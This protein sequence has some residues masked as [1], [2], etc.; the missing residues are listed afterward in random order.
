MAVQPPVPA[1]PQ[2]A[3]PAPPKKSGCA[4]CSVGCLGCLGVFVIVTLLLAT[5]G[6]FFFVASANA[7]VA[8]PAALLVATT[9]VEVGHNDSGYAPA[10]SGQSLDAG[11]S[12]RTGSTG[13]ATIQFPDGS[14]TR[15]APDTTVT[16]TSAQLNSAGTLKSATLSEKIGRTLSVVQKLT[17]G[18]SFSVGG[19]TVTAAVRGTQFEVVVNKDFSNLFKVFDGVVQVS[20]Q[21]TVTLT[22]GQQVSADSNG[23]VGRPGPIQADLHDPY[24]LETQCARA[25]AQGTAAG[26]TQTTTGQISNGETVEVDYT[27]SGASTTA[28]L[29]Y[30]GSFI[31]LSVVDPAGVTHASRSGQP[32]VVMTIGRGPGVY[33]ALVHAI[34]VTPGEAFAVSFAS[35]AACSGA[36]Y[37]TGGVVRQT[38]SN[39]ELARSLA[40]SGAAGITIQVQGTSPTSARVYYAYSGYGVEFSWT[41]DFYAATPNLGYVFTQVSFRGIN[42]TTQVISRINAAGA[43]VTSIPQDYTV[44]RVYSCNGPDGDMMI[45]EGHR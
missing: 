5:G 18:A 22:A 41:I 43:A 37:D 23:R 10:A 31:N 24:Q 2:A 32:P 17:G 14:L 28:A 4:G 1:V 21:T 15:V 3:A 11:S 6:Y 33:K 16:I 7:G 35:D 20:G 44:D 36:T 25:V 40:D 34:D 42:I 8:S 29:C 38:L 27:S 30:P 13:R 45:I 12:V 26:T 19:H 39:G 9:P